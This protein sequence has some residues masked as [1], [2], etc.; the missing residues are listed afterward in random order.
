MG[1][2]ESSV[3][4]PWSQK[5]SLYAEIATKKGEIEEILFFLLKQIEWQKA[6][7]RLSFIVFAI[8]GK[9]HSSY[10]V[11]TK[12]IA[13]NDKTNLLTIYAPTEFFSKLLWE[14]TAAKYLFH[15]DMY[16]YRFSIMLKYS[17]IRML[18]PYWK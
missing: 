16:V 8:F 12:K 10:C 7:R 6:P 15:S 2:R 9:T 13:K 4:Q 5:G 3:T 14:I 18:D 17:Q 11:I 1:R